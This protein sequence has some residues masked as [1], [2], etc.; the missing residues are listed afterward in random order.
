MAMGW[1]VAKARMRLRVLST[2]R[3]VRR[4]ARR[5][6]TN[7]HGLDAGAVVLGLPMGADTRWPGPTVPA[8][9]LAGGAGARLVVA[10]MAE[11]GVGV[12]VETNGVGEGEGALADGG[13]W[14]AQCGA[15]RC[16]GVVLGVLQWAVCV[17]VV[18]G[19]LSVCPFVLQ[20]QCVDCPGALRRPAHRPTVPWGVMEGVGGE[21][22]V[23][24]TD[25]ASALP[26]PEPARPSPTVRS[27]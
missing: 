5:E 1:E 25:V 21:V 2:A 10:A 24:Q 4:E 16:Y 13:L 11:G 9:A 8:A 3:R 23:V 22:A 12:K 7:S 27:S 14:I 15:V 19:V 20:R 17:D 18:V 6:P 26:S